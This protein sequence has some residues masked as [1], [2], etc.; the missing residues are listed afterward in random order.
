MRTQSSG[1]KVQEK[2]VSESEGRGLNPLEEKF[3]LR[4]RGGRGSSAAVSEAPASALMLPSL[5]C[6]LIDVACDTIWRKTKVVL[7]KVIS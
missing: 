5:T 1:E 3:T 4:V 2:K 7:V 6:T